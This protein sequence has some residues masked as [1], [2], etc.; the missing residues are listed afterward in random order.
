MNSRRLLSVNARRVSGSNRRVVGLRAR[1]HCS[2]PVPRVTVQ[3]F[4][5]FHSDTSPKSRFE[6]VSHDLGLKG[7]RDPNSLLAAP[8]ARPPFE[9]NLAVDII[10][11]PMML[12]RG[13]L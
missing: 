7:C 5:V 6:P 13:S 4:L 12:V 1:K 10:R 2:N 9:F 8:G 3:S 11:Y